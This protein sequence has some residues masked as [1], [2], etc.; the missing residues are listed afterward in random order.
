ML[1]LELAADRIARLVHCP[2]DEYL[3]K[4]LYRPGATFGRSDFSQSLVNLC[5]PDGST[6]LFSRSIGEEP[7]AWIVRGTHLVDAETGE[8]WGQLEQ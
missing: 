5:W 7:R 3:Q 6:W 2:E 4:P 1:D 8:V